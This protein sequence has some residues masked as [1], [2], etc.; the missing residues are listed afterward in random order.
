MSIFLVFIFFS[1]MTNF[2]MGDCR[3][4]VELPVYISKAS[5]SH[6]TWLVEPYGHVIQPDLT[7]NQKART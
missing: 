6:A 5:V 4:L 2:P 1:K 7:A 3:W